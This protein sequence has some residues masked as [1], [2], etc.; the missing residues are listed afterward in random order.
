VNA[1]VSLELAISVPKAARSKEAGANAVGIEQ[2]S[3]TRPS[4]R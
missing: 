1:S 3:M 2:V 4:G